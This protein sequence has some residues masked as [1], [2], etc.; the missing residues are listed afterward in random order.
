MTVRSPAGENLRFRFTTLDQM[1]NT[2]VPVGQ[3]WRLVDA[4]GDTILSGYGTGAPPTLY[5][6]AGYTPF[7]A[8]NDG[9]YGY[10]I[11]SG[12]ALITEDAD[13]LL[14]EMTASTS[15]EITLTGLDPTT[16]AHF[17]L[18]ALQLWCTISAPVAPAAGDL[19]YVRSETDALNY[20]ESALH[21]DGANWELRSSRVIAGVYTSGTVNLGAGGINGTRLWGP[22]WFGNPAVDKTYRSLQTEFYYDTANG[23]TATAGGVQLTSTTEDVSAVANT[24]IYRIG[25]EVGAGASWTVRLHGLRAVEHAV[26]TPGAPF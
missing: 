8:M 4:N 6:A 7:A 16:G 2:T 23:A 3:P 5:D 26:N 14:V 13:G 21:Y 22:Q 17:L 18:H 15:W 10:S 11:D 20:S 1:L 9:G 24:Q 12:A 25:G 19:F